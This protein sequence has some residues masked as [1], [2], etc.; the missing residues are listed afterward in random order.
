M[1]PSDI[2]ISI[3]PPHVEDI[4]AGRKTVELRRRFPIAMGDGGLMLIYASSPEQSLIGAARIEG[5]RRMTPAGLW[6]SFREQACVP[7][8][9]FNDYFCGAS[10]GFG[11][12]L[13][14]V[15]RFEEAIPVS[16]LKERFRFSPPQSYRYV[17]GLLAG[18]LQDERIQVPDR[19][20][21]RDRSRGQPAGRRRPH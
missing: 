2:I 1:Q 17:R 12:L 13:G 3:R 15:V 20:E 4:L 8:A 14:S 10:E 5:V 11:V 18:L 19:H 9:Y 6:R 21:H 16:E 7:K